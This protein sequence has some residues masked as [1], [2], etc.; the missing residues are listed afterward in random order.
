MVS[1]YLGTKNQAGFSLMELLVTVSIIGVL[2]TAGVPVYRRMVSKAKTSEAKVNLGAMA[3]VES[4]FQSE[5]STYG[6]NLNMM[7]YSMDG[8]PAN[9]LYAMGFMTAG[10][11][12]VAALPAGNAAITANITNYYTAANIQTVF[13]R[14][15]GSSSR[16]GAGLAVGAAGTKSVCPA[17]EATN[18]AGAATYELM[19]AGA[20]RSGTN[21]DTEGAANND[22]W[23]MNE[24][25]ALIH[26]TDGT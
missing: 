8:A 6:T 15:V 9:S 10:C 5:Y 19:A 18:T 14:A 4:M 26:V 17:R 1:K 7:G 24:T 12:N 13:G 2:S 20:I 23:T 16:D 21:V 25:R 11:G 22:V 3:N